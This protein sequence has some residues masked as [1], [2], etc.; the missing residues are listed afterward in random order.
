MSFAPYDIATLLAEVQTNGSKLQGINGSKL[1]DVNEEARRQCLAAARS[2]VYALE[3]PLEA[4]LRLNYAEPAH[5]A[6]IRT[7][8]DLNLFEKLEQGAGDPVTTSK[9]AESTGA[10]PALLPRLLKHLAA[11]GTIYESHVD[12]WL[13]TAL[14]KALIVP[15]Y[16][17]AFPVCAHIISPTTQ[18]IPEFLA[19]TKYQN[20][21][22]AVHSPF[23]LAFNTKEHGFAW[24]AQRS[25]LLTAFNSHM[26]GTHAGVSSWMDEGYY[27][28]EENLVKGSKEDIPFFVDVG[29]SKGHDIQE[30]CRRHPNLNQKFVLQDIPDVIKEASGLDPRIETM[31]HDF[32]AEQPIKGEQ[33]SPKNQERGA[34][35][36]NHV[37]QERKHTSCTESYTTGPTRSVTR[38]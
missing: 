28:F 16:K 11:M 10:D 9:L 17:D 2:L 38:S 6:A 20:P 18:K 37:Q 29:G 24:M 19:M 36:L 14:S 31:G 3:S 33:H 22:I 34:H 5:A 23:Q 8:V 32:F 7:A 26:A 25:E 27:P 13:P 15:M 35:L 4:I 12:K 30:L 1:Q 21:E